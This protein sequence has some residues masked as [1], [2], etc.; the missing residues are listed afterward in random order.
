MDLYIE[1]IKE[2]LTGFANC[3]NIKLVMSYFVVV[4]GFL[5]NINSWEFLASVL[6]LICFDFISAIAVAKATG[7]LIESRKCVRSAFKMIIYG[8]IISSAHL[9]DKCL[10]ISTWSLSA[11]YISLGFLAS[12]EFISILENFGK[13]GYSTPKK[14]LNNFKK[15]VGDN[16]KCDCK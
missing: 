12:T 11:E 6:I 1:H 3:I 16:K 2:V 5:F 9:V 13:A 8:I 15:S 14:L 10:G 7:E 4:F